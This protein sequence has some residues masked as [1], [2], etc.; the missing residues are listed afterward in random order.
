MKM[1]SVTF[2]IMILLGGIV[3]YFIRWQRDINYARS[4]DIINVGTKGS[5][6]TK[7]ILDFWAV[8]KKLF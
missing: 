1:N 8:L 4:F 5:E 2:L 7:A 3:G 6:A